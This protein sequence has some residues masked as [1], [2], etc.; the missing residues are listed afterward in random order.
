MYVLY[1]INHLLDDICTL[2]LLKINFQLFL[3]SSK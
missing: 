2:N 3:D 1:N